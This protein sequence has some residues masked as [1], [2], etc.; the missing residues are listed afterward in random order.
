MHAPLILVALFCRVPVFFASLTIEILATLGTR[1]SR[2]MADFADWL[3]AIHIHVALVSAAPTHY[4]LALSNRV[5]G[6]LA[7]PAAL[8]GGFPLIVL[9]IVIH[10][11]KIA[12]LAALDLFAVSDAV[13]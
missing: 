8:F 3:V 1:V 12:A 7:P 6:L 2:A 4:Q 11:S 5:P 9:A 13:S 10:M